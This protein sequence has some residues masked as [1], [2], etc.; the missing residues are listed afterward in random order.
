MNPGT[1]SGGWNFVMAAYGVT[2][3]VLFIY[4]VSIV[5]RLRQESKNDE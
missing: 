4:G 5:S 1:L 2:F 3:S